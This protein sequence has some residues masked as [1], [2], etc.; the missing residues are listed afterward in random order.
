MKNNLR[1]LFVLLALPF[2][3][4]GQSPT[5]EKIDPPS[6]WTGSTINPVRVLLRGENLK[7]SSVVGEKGLLTGNFKV[8]ENGHY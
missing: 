7:G 6:W 2:A 1:S 4:F 3:L 8:S 5:V